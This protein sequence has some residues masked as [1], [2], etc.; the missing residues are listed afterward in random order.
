MSKKETKK[1]EDKIDDLNAV[2][3]F[4]E[5]AIITLYNDEDEPIDFFEIASIEHDEKFYELLQPVEKT[6]GIEEDEAVIF[7]TVTQ[8]AGDDEK[9]Y[10]PVFEESILEAVFSLYLQAA[11]DFESSGCGSEGGCGGGCG[12][13]GCSGHAEV[14][15]TEKPVAKKAPAKKTP[16][17]D[18][19][20]AAKKTP[21]KK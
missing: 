1:I 18:K 13:G 16:A 8:D 21:A 3:I 7:E 6:E 12:G 17:G 4:G 9:L 20:P 10:K 19:K 5:D 11:A 14:P 15:T 2:E